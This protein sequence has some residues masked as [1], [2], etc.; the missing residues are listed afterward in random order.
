HPMAT[1]VADLKDRGLLDSTLVIWMGEF[2]RSP[3]HGKNHYARAW[4]TV[5]AGAG[6]RGGRA[7]GRTDAKGADVQQRPVSPGDFIATGRK[8]R[9]HAQPKNRP[10][11]GRPPRAKGGKAP[12]TRH[13]AVRVGETGARPDSL[14]PGGGPRVSPGATPGTPPGGGP[15]GVPPPPLTPRSRR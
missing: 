12:H 1:L 10:P 5:L 2:G 4:T 8:A 11:R 3:G 7:V 9:R 6:V 15:P 14:R 13:P